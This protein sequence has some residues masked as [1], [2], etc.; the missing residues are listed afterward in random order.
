MEHGLNNEG[1]EKY[2]GVFSEPIVVDFV[3]YGFPVGY[4]YIHMPRASNR[5]H[6]SADAYIHEVDEY[7]E[8]EVSHGA[9]LGP[10]EGPPFAW[11]M[12]S[13]LMSRPKGETGR[14]RVIMDLSFPVGYSVND[15][16][17]QDTYL[18]TKFKLRLPSALSLRDMIREE[19]VGAILWSRDFERSYRQLR[20]D[21][22]D[23]PLLGIQ[24]GGG[25]D[26]GQGSSVKWFLDLAIPFGLRNGAKCMQQVSQSVIDILRSEGFKC[27]CY[28]DDLAAVHSSLEQA[29]ASFDRCGEILK[30]LGIAEAR[31]KQCR[32]TT[33]MVFLGVEFDTIAMTMRIPDGKIDNVVRL[34]KIWKDKE[35][36]TPGELRS[37]LG[38]LFFLAT[39][40]ST[41]RLFCNRIL[42][43]L[44]GATEHKP[45]IISQEAQLDL[46]WVIQF[47]ADYN[48]LDIIDKPPTYKHD[49]IIDSCL[50]G[51]GGHLG[52]L[53][54]GV[55]FPSAVQKQGYTIADLEML[56]ALV[57]LRLLARELEGHIVELR[58]DNAP[59]VAVLQ[60]GRGRCGKLLRCA[61]AIWKVT[62]RHHIDI[63]VSHIAGKLNVLADA[64]SR[65]HKNSTAAN[66]VKARL[67]RE[68]AQLLD[69]S[70]DMFDF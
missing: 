69:V 60:S 26:R 55:E 6:A 39:C 64:L 45:I 43:D 67:V 25:W 29:T 4:E 62:A 3:R 53:W 35:V 44:R 28:I 14:R 68:G 36:C 24:W 33:N 54:Y 32:P 10:F 20:T 51:C 27:I 5:N 50:T 70:E 34:V 49:L 38:K 13:P 16:I 12:Q 48:G 58:C 40:N 52:G 15:G 2:K 57:A 22:L 17:P 59:A 42:E 41:L 18:G 37:L 19:G 47:M 30:E 21:P 8:K 1:W 65:A 61:R 66:E 56:N 63:R 11:C 23:Y 9:M 46:D 31:D 7:I